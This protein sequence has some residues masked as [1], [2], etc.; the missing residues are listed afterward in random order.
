M[1]NSWHLATNHLRCIATGDGGC[2]RYHILSER[3]STANG[4]LDAKAAMQLLSEVAQS[5]TQWSVAYNLTS[6]EVSVVIGQSYKTVFP[7]HLDRVN[8]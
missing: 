6:G 8:P 2:Q 3:L 1:S 5:G 7:F 4:H